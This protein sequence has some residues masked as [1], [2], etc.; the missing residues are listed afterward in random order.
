MTILTAAAGLLDVLGFGFGLAA[1]RL[2]ERH[3]RL[4]DIGFDLEFPQ[5]AIDDDFQVQLAHPGNNGLRR[6]FVGTHAERR[7][8]LGKLLKSK[9]HLLL[10]WLRL[11]FDGHRDDRLGKFHH[12]EQTGAF[13]PQSVSPVVAPFNP[14]AA[15]ISPACA[16]SISS[17]LLACIFN[18]RPM[19]SFVPLVTFSTG[20]PVLVSRNTHENRST[21]L[22]TDRT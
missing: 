1:D 6:F 15:T 12:F 20:V 4:S 18:R 3:F 10:I 14:T 13:R 11:G 16:A 19:R 17:R 9:T 7:I 22:Q 8:F 5:Q 2:S 21:G